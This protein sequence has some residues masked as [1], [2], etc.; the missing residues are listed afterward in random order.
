MG[1]LEI[2]GMTEHVWRAT[3][4]LVNAAARTV[5]KASADAAL[6]EERPSGA[7]GGAAGARPSLCGTPVQRVQG[8]PESQLA[9]HLR[10]GGVSRRARS[11]H[12]R[13]R[14]QVAALPPQ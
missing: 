9:V 14:L 6:A 13:V 2:P 3:E 11:Q 1:A 5:G 8:G 12:E 7:H 4:R 10:A